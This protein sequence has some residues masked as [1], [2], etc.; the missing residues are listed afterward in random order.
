[1]LATMRSL[2]YLDVSCNP[3]SDATLGEL[4]AA[5]IK[6]LWAESLPP[7]TGGALSQHSHIAHLSLTYCQR[8]ATAQLCS[9]TR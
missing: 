4:L 5:P 1:M 8:S 7:L 6:E 2:K 3:L 9:R